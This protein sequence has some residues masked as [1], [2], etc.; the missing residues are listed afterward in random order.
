[1]SML[2]EVMIMSRVINTGT[3]MSIEKN[4]KEILGL[5]RNLTRYYDFAYC[6]LCNS[7]HAALHSALFAEG[8]RYGDKVTVKSDLVTQQLKQF[9]NYLGLR[10]FSAIYLEEGKITPEIHM[11]SPGSRPERV[12]LSTAVI[13]FTQLGYGHA[14]AMLTDTA[15]KYAKADRLKIFGRQDLRTMWE[16]KESSPDAL[17][18]IQFNYRLSPLVAALI[19]NSLIE[20]GQL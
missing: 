9:F 14:A 11:L 13:D 3:I 20:R 18:T 5:E 1:M 6:S 19:R 17:P 8:Y 10:V 4:E 12:P 15:I 2:K 16:G 7:F